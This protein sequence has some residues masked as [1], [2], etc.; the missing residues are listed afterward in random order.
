ME[1]RFFNESFD[2][3]PPEY[4]MA[5]FRNT[6]NGKL[7]L[8]RRNEDPDD[9][10]YDEQFFESYTMDWTMTDML[11]VVEDFEMLVCELND[12][13]EE[14]GAENAAE[15]SG[16]IFESEMVALRARRLCLLCELNA[17]EVVIDR[18]A[19]LLMDAMIIA[20]YAISLDYK[21]YFADWFKAA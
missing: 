13:I 12:A 3:T 11:D 18:E 21:L 10:R 8:A 17:P 20:R 7:T 4:A 15:C 19:C 2:L 1:I 5:L 14:F 9:D 16:L 6:H